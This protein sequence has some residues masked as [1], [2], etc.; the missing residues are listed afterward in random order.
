MGFVYIWEHEACTTAHSARRSSALP[1]NY[2]PVPNMKTLSPH[3]RLVAALTVFFGSVIGIHFGS[4]YSSS[5]L[6]LITLSALCLVSFVAC[7]LALYRC[8]KPKTTAAVVCLLT[9]AAFSSR[10]ETTS[11]KLFNS[12]GTE[13]AYKLNVEPLDLEGY[14]ILGTVQSDGTVQSADGKPVLDENGNLL[15]VVTDENGNQVV[16][17]VD[18]DTGGT[19]EPKVGLPCAIVVG[20]LV[21]AGGSYAAYKIYCWANRLLNPT[22]PPPTNPPPTNPPATNPPATNSPPKKVMTKAQTVTATSSLVFI[23]ELETNNLAMDS[24]VSS[25]GWTD[26]QGNPICY[27]LEGTATGSTTAT[28]TNRFQTSTNLINWETEAYS[29]V[30]WVSAGPSRYGTSNTITIL[31]D[32]TGCPVSTN[33]TTIADGTNVVFLGST[34]TTVPVRSGVPALFYRT[35][36]V[37]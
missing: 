21:L 31:Y 12:G 34:V 28:A 6:L 16:K 7:W 2:T 9:F 27:Y 26:W 4:I 37:P 8:K 10:A 33:W 32:K 13:P 35:A 15:I 23:G 22:N 25:K 1:E 30:A 24:S 20:G 36:P 5:W 29:F 3:L 14:T 17:A 11:F 18:K 19:I